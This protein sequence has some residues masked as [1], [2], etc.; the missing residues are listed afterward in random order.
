M[1]E[2]IDEKIEC[3]VPALALE[4]HDNDEFLQRKERIRA[5]VRRLY[6]Y[7]DFFADDPD[8]IGPFVILDDMKFHA[9][10]LGYQVWA[11]VRAVHKAVKN[12]CE[13]GGK[14][15]EKVGVIV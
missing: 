4:H 2:I 3:F 13:K 5:A 10:A 8:N 14:G 11:R 6:Q 7:G 1:Q 12:M 15:G 9:G